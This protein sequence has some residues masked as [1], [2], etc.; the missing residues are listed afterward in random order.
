MSITAP[1][2]YQVILEPCIGQFC[3]LEFS[4][5][6]T[7]I[8]VRGIFSCAL[9]DSRKARER[10][11]AKHSMK[12]RRSVGAVKTLSMREKNEGN[13]RGGG[14]G[15]ATPVTT[16]TSRSWKVEVCKKKNLLE[17]VINQQSAAAKGAR[18]VRSNTIFFVSYVPTR[19]LARDRQT[20]RQRSQGPQQQLSTSPIVLQR[21]FS[22]EINK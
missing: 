7:R 15:R 21:V 22:G 5:V 12:N 20:T 14:K 16:A 9:I 8:N 6:R 3:E 1:V 18:Q 19:P 10:K 11:L 13:N 17:E 4:R 2:V